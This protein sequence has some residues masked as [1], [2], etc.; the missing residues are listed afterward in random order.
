MEHVLILTV[1][2]HANISIFYSTLCRRG[3]GV[4]KKEYS[5]YACKKAENCGPP[6][7]GNI[8]VSG[9]YNSF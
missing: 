9:F 6:L 2:K 7:N 5:L 1:C 8:V 3:E 4:S